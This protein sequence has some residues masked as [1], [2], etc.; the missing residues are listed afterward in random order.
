MTMK[1]LL[2]LIPALCL[3]FASCDLA[4][5]K[6]NYAAADD[7]FPVKVKKYAEGEFEVNGQ[8]KKGQMVLTPQI[9]EFAPGEHYVFDPV[10]EEGFEPEPGKFKFTWYL[11][12]EA[13]LA[14]WV[15]LDLVKDADTPTFDATFPS[16]LDP[17]PSRKYTLYFE[18]LDTEKNLRASGDMIP[19]FLRST[20]D[21][22][23][24]FILKDVDGKTDMDQYL[25]RGFTPLSGWT[26]PTNDELQ[27]SDSLRQEGIIS[28]ATGMGAPLEGSPV[29]LISQEARYWWH[30]PIR[31]ENVNRGGAWHIATTADMYTLTRSLNEELGRF[32][33]NFYP[34]YQPERYNIQA[35]SYRVEM[36]FSGLYSMSVR[37]WM[38]NDNQIWGTSTEQMITTPTKFNTWAT[39][40]D[41]FPALTASHWLCS[42]N[43]CIFWDPNRGQL[44]YMNYNYG[45]NVYP[46]TAY[47]TAEGDDLLGGKKVDLLAMLAG[48]GEIRNLGENAKDVNSHM[49]LKNKENGKHYLM[50]WGDRLSMS[51]FG[52]VGDKWIRDIPAGADII[53]TPQPK[54]T[55][56]FFNE[57]IYYVKGNQIWAYE[58]RAQPFGTTL[59]LSDYQRD[60]KIRIGQG[61]TVVKLKTIGFFGIPANNYFGITV[62]TS[63]PDGGYKYYVFISVGQVDEFNPEPLY[64]LEGEG[65]PVDDY[66][67]LEYMMGS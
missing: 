64:V 35:L 14:R 16:Y 47:L 51:S 10:F 20:I 11:M 41:G 4:D 34:F 61:E 45:V 36:W 58:D 49:I 44:C 54:M 66:T 1:K 18:A 32:S 22:R 8:D 39:P 62:L 60:T 13:S 25:I 40:D 67:R 38:V 29:A 30:D 24:I 31:E 15:R 28:R 21:Y 50:K 19:D 55:S 9:G 33:D 42:T 6:L 23:G 43:G 17:D 53:A 65:T 27:N 3:A 56:S 12:Y 2:Y 37:M 63:T 59:P 5:D 46:S 26:L 7:V 48:G 52:N 57:V